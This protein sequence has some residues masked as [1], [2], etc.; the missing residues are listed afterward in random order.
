MDSGF[1]AAFTGLVAR[2]Q[3]LDVAANNLANV[4]TTG[5]KAQR[6]FYSSLEASMKRGALSPLNRAVDDFGVLGGAAVDLQNGSLER[7]GNDLDVA[8]E[9][10]GF[11]VAQ[12]KNGVRYTRNGG[13]HQTQSGQLVT[14]AGDP[15]IDR[16]VR[17][18]SRRV[19]SRSAAT[20]PYR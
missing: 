9:G 17:L 14:A 5:Y 3:A 13:F 10:P 7:T 8:L 4:N 18:L 16:M 12:T 20:A 15:V 6:E 1:Y 2:T 11:F 19:K